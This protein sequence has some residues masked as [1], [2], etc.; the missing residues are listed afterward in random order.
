MTRRPIPE[1]A[2]LTIA[3]RVDAFAALGLELYLDDG[4][5]RA[6]GPAALIEAARP[7]IALHKIA[8]VRYLS[9]MPR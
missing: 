8:L 2:G 7:V 1:N 9:P 4:Q 5:L 6:S 3:D